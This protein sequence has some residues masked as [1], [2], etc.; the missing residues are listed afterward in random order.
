MPD[1]RAIVVIL[2]ERNGALSAR[3]FQDLISMLTAGWQGDSGSVIKFWQ[4]Y[5]KSLGVSA[6]S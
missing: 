4:I 1:I 6:D 5:R 3:P 2:V